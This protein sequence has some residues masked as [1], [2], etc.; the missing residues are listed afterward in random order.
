M[1]KCIMCLHDMEI[2]D[3][4]GCGVDHE[5]ETCTCKI[6]QRDHAAALLKR[7]RLQRDAAIKSADMWYEA[8]HSANERLT[9]WINN[10]RGALNECER[11]RAERDA[12]DSARLAA[13][14]VAEREHARADAA[15]S[16]ADEVLNLLMDLMRSTNVASNYG[17]TRSAREKVQRWLVAHDA[18]IACECGIPLNLHSTLPCGRVCHWVRKDGKDVRA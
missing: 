16:E 18:R 12:A 9:G 14:Q 5:F 4:D 8:T 7:V 3:E 2:H 6:T 15:K 1:S 13:L 17:E 11:L 10:A